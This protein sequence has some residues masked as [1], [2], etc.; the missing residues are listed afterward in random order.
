[1]EE[2]KTDYRPGYQ[3]RDQKGIYYLT[4]QV[5]YWIDIFSRKRYRDIFVESLKHCQKE[6]GLKVHA[7]VIM[8]NHVH[9]I[10]STEKGELSSVIGSLKSFTSKKITASIQEQGESRRGWI[11]SLFSFAA[12]KHKRNSKYQLWPHENHPIELISNHFFE[13]KLDYICNPP[14]N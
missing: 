8:T 6:K 3:I 4:F 2:Y 11:L 5:I 14:Q 9:L 12:K 10:L 13:Q 7:W 1:M